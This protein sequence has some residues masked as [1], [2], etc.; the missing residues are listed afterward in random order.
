MEN[1]DYTKE[2]CMDVTIAKPELTIDNSLVFSVI[3]I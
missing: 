2:S 3:Y 1:I